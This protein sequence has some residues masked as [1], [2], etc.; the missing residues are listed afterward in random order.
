M[1]NEWIARWVGGWMSK[2]ICQKDRQLN[3][4]AVA[5]FQPFLQDKDEDVN[6]VNLPHP[7]DS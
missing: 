6:G 7:C 3:T 1:D 4:L 5:V 2:W